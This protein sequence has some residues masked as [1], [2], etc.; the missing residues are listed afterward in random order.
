MTRL[1][2]IML[3]MLLAGCD[4]TVNHEFSGVVECNGEIVLTADERLIAAMSAFY[5]DHPELYAEYFAGQGGD[6]LIGPIQVTIPV[7]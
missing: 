5:Q 4:Y 6:E 7:Y 1:I 2:T 3:L